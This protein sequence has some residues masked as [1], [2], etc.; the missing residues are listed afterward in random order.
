M[1]RS[2]NALGQ[3][4]VE[5]GALAEAEPLLRRAYAIRLEGLPVRHLDI[6]STQ[7]NLGLCLIRQGRY[8]EGETLLREALSIRDEK[9][10]PGQWVRAETRSLLGEALAGQRK[11]DEAEPL[12]LPA[13]D[14]LN[15]SDAVP[16][17]RKRAAR[18]RIERL[19]RWWGRADKA[20]AWR[21]SLTTLQ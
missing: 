13:F 7:A 21:A 5:K 20:R 15:S 19:Y 4:L 17:S 11:F 16:E 2:L 1:A 14:A 6:A 3:V 10:P 12:L 18:D 9:L 8:A